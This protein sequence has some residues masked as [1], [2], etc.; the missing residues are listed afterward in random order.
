[1]DEFAEAVKE[2]FGENLTEP[3]PPKELSKPTQA[4]Y[5]LLMH[6]ACKD[7]NTTTKLWIVFDARAKSSTGTLL[8]DQLLVGPIVHVPLVD[9]LLRFHVHK[10]ALAMDIS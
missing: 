2:Y 1:M 9:V 4:V 3:V 10:V 6:A 5:Y 8:N 7:S